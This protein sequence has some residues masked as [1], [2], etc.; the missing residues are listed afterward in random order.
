MI[1]FL[2]SSAIPRITTIPPNISPHLSATCFFTSTLF[3][4]HTVA[5]QKWAHLVFDVFVITGSDRA[6]KT[7]KTRKAEKHEHKNVSTKM[8]KREGK[9]EGMNGRGKGGKGGKYKSCNPV[10]RVL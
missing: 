4:T 10:H 7:K 3:P 1:V 6:N 2:F 8:E 5:D 9:S